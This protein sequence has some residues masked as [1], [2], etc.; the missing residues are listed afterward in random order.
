M[1]TRWIYPISG[2]Y[3]NSEIND[4]KIANTINWKIDA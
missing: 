2:Q 3:I 1:K 4:E